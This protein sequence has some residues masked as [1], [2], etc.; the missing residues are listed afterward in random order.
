MNATSITIVGLLDVVLFFWSF[1][2]P[3]EG[4]FEIKWETTR[5]KL[6][7]D[8]VER[9]PLAG[10]GLHRKGE[11]DVWRGPSLLHPSK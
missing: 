8:Y 10:S 9:L 1:V 2:S 4:C 6:E 11:G 3:V 7:K 5:K